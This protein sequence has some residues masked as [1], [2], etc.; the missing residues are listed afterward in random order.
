VQSLEAVCRGAALTLIAWGP[1]I[2][3]SLSSSRGRLSSPDLFSTL[4]ANRNDGRLR[5]I[6]PY[7]PTNRMSIVPRWIYKP[8]LPWVV[9]ST[10][11]VP[12]AHCVLPPPCPYSLS[13]SPAAD[14]VWVHLKLLCIPSPPSVMLAP[15]VFG[16]WPSGP[17]SASAVEVHRRRHFGSRCVVR[18]PHHREWV[19]LG[20]WLLWVA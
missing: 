3:P 9:S 20:V 8:V 6:R 2:G 10:Q 7:T 18:D 5:E 12:V 15:L 16:T 1:S 4:G 19:P 17:L 13:S 11:A 14:L